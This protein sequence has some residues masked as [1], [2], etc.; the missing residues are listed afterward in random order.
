M[1]VAQITYRLFDKKDL[2][3]I[4]SLWENF[5]GWGAITSEQ[6][7]QWYIDTPSGSCLIVVA[8]DETDTVLGQIVLVPAQV[9][10]NGQVL[11]AVRLSAPIL[12]PELRQVDL[13]SRSHPVIMMV[14]KSV[15]F[16]TEKGY[17]I[18]YSLPAHAWI[19]ALKILQRGG[20]WDL[21]M[22]AYECRSISLMDETIWS[23][24][25]G[26]NLITRH[27]HHFNTSYD[28]LF[29]EAT[30]QFPISLCIVRNAERLQWK[31]SHHIVIEIRNEQGLMGYAAY[32]KNGLLVDILARTKD[33]LQLVFTASLKALHVQN[34]HRVKAPFDE[35]KFMMNEPVR[36]LLEGLNHQ[37]ANFQFA[38]ASYPLQKS[39]DKHALAPEQWYMMPDD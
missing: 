36:N 26:N 38:I 24:C 12:H 14:M 31:I 37:P 16:A 6:F 27:V 8:T 7:T 29:A 2:P 21:Q 28:E 11:K 39:I 30:R 33:D 10:L 1:E 23:I 17:H 20:M 32:K 35:I 22:A 3:G 34:D 9:I 18:L 4:L 25:S 15:E 19:G 13:R 5:S